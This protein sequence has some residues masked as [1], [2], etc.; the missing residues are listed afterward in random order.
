MAD[1]GDGASVF[2]MFIVGAIV[3]P[4][5][6]VLQFSAHASTWVTMAITIVVAIVLSLGLLRPLKAILFTLQ[7]THKAEEGKLRE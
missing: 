6:F 2:V 5:A 1:T 4:L 7:W 3:V